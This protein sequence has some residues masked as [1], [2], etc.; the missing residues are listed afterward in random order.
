[1][2]RIRSILTLMVVGAL[3]ACGG[4]EEGPEPASDA[5]V[6]E[7]PAGAMEGMPGMSGM[8]MGGGMMEE[9]HAHMQAMEGMSGGGMM[10][11]MPQHR[12]MVANMIAQMNRE[13]R[14]MNMT[15]DQEW[16]STI[17]ALRQDLVAIPEMSAAETEAF[18][19]EHH[20]RVMR[21]MEMHQQM[22]TGMSM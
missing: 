11:M 18:M 1:M 21:L 22:M 17:E 3:G 13:M 15:A 10:Q 8:A 5:E 6:T 19:P 14:D 2:L 4:T 20:A 9:M 16:T 12:Q 7:M